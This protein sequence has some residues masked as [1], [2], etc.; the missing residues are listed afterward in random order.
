MAPLQIGLLGATGETGS[1]IF[2]GLVSSP[3]ASDF[4]ITALVRPSSLSKA[5][6]QA[7]KS[8]KNV[9]LRSLDLTAS[10]EEI[11]SSLQGIEILISA[12][13]A[14]DQ[15]SQIQLATAAKAAGVKRFIPCAFITVIPAGGIHL[16][17]DQKQ[18]VYNHIFQLGLSYTIIDVG[19]WYQI[20]LPR[21]PSGKL[22]AV[23][24]IVSPEIAG[25][26]NVL[27]GLT[28]LRDIGK[29]VARIMQDERTINKWVFVYNELWSQNAV[30][31]LVEKRL[32]EKID[33][34]Y[35]SEKDLL[36][37]IENPGE[38]PNA[39]FVKVPAQYMRSWGIRGDNTPEYA[40]YLGYVTSKELY[41]DLEFTSFERYL[42]D[43][44][45][46]KIKPVYEEL[47]AQFE[48]SKKA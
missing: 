35:L 34:T 7:L 45:E 41:P 47:R 26:G 28:D 29:Y 17:R 6:N 23:A 4:H 43:A 30:Y 12:I 18:E 33:R 42:E 14:T 39:L 46:G 31:D 27:S 48:A 3:E 19:W 44:L 32:G 9:S 24:S 13:G 21:V 25:G 10:A 11:T 20:S 36:A 8:H 15:L 1:S 5:A 38:G 37:R 16:L 40:K 2:N 22:D